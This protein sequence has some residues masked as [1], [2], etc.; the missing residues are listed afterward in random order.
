ML[1]RE[2]DFKQKSSYEQ[3]I[4]LAKGA[5]GEDKEGYRSEFLKLAKSTALMARDLLIIAKED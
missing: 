2:S 3:V 1:L 4:E 5:L